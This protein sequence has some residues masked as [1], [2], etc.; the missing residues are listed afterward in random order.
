MKIE[1][2]KYH[3]TLDK[4]ISRHTQGALAGYEK[5]GEEVQYILTMWIPEDFY[6]KF[7]KHYNDFINNLDNEK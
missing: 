1:N 5:K 6:V 3:K 4:Y 2:K 7:T